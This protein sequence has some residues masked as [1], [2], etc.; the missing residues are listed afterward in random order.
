MV[1][2]CRGLA[3]ARGQA[4]QLCKKS[5]RQ[6]GG[7]LGAEVYVHLIQFTMQGCP[8]PPEHHHT[9]EL[10]THFPHALPTRD[11][12]FTALYLSGLYA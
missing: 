5:H 9:V 10:H 11:L 7:G 3:K 6:I 1:W 4:L 12:Y 2:S 8:T